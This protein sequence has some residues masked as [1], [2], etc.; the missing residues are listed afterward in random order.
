MLL[1]PKT[2]IKLKNC[3]TD[4]NKENIFRKL[5]KSKLISYRMYLDKKET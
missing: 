5:S 2:K 1:K 4:K 3:L